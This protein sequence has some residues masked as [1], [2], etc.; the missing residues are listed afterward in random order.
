MIRV[1]LVDDHRIVREGIR[2]LLVEEPDIEVVG[3]A[4]NG[5]EAIKLLRSEP[6]D[7]AVLDMSM[8][9]RS[10]IELLKQIHG[11]WPRLRLLV[12]SMHEEQ[13]YAIRVLRAGA[14]GY[15]TKDSAG[16]QLVTALRKIAA[17]GVY[18]TPEQAESLANALHEA[19]DD[20]LPHTRLSDREFQIFEC[21]A[22]GQTVG[23]IADA[24]FLSIKTVSTHKTRVLQKLEV[25]NTA[26]LIR[27]ALRHGLVDN[28]E[29][30]KR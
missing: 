19:P 3:E 10:G 28:A 13:P 7:I 5:I 29:E 9:G 20:Q 17:G 27:Y 21:L 22:R 16:G 14:S 15:L 25:S 24:L 6:V 12:L 4:A 2:Q 23:E 18:I 8:P 11:E 26:Q 30:G 1:I